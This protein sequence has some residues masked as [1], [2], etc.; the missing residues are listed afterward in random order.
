MIKAYE[1]HETQAFCGPTL[2]QSLPS[3]GGGGW[4]E[5][6]GENET[7]DPGTLDAAMGWAQPLLYTWWVNN[8]LVCGL[9]HEIYDLPYIWKNQP[10]WRTHIFQRDWNDQPV[11]L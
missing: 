8:I 1:R 10:N 9:E 2:C 7:N 4:W 5:A 6:K 3:Q 11:S